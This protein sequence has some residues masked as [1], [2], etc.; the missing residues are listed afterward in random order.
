MQE[1]TAGTVAEEAGA[2]ATTSAAADVSLDNAIETLA[3]DPANTEMVDEILNDSLRS[4]N[5]SNED[6]SGDVDAF[7]TVDTTRSKRKYNK[8]YYEPNNFQLFATTV[9]VFFCHM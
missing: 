4:G 7:S 3:A 1:Q 8:L 2:L 9:C 6:I 5:S